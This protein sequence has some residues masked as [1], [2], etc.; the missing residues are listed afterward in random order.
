MGIGRQTKHTFVR[1][2]NDNYV[3]IGPT[4]QNNM[5][6]VQMTDV[7]LFDT[8]NIILRPLSCLLNKMR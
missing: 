6:N 4:E 3:Q 1:L 8:Q 5:S 2:F 7:R